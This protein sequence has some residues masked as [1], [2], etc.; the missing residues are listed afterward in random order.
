VDDDVFIGIAVALLFLIMFFSTAHLALRT[1]WR[2]RLAEILESR[3]RSVWLAQLLAQRSTLTLALAILRAA[4]M[5]ALIL[6][7]VHLHQSDLAAEWSAARYASTYAWSLA[8]VLI[9]GVAI[10]NAWARYDGETL[11]AHVLPLLHAMQIVLRPVLWVLRPIDELVRRLTGAPRIDDA[12]QAEMI[13]QEILNVVSEGEKQGAFDVEEKEM[14]EAVIELRDTQAGRIMTPRTEVIGLAVDATL[15]DVRQLITKEG[16]SRLPVYEETI[17]NVLGVL[18]AKDLLT[19]ED[20]A[21]FSV[22]AMMRQVPFVPET[23]L[24]RELLREFQRE[25]IQIAIVLDEYGGTAGLVSIEDILEE[26]VG[27]IVDEYEPPEPEP[28]VVIDADTVEIDARVHID[29]LNAELDIHLPEDADFD[30][31]GGFVFSTLGKI[32]ASGEAIEHDNLRIEVLDAAER[33]IN[34]L[35]VHVDRDNHNGRDH[36]P[37]G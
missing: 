29:E 16:H 28:I 9:F 21:S 34:R 13:E 22:R 12:A 7:I 26:L 4:A 37:H 1:F 31:V 5:L 32:P 10:P 33:K 24:L 11:L 19:V 8:L 20:P 18:Y 27:E 6:V 25:K 36:D 30:T 3:G 2:V 14:I 15:D 23:K 35:R 17:D